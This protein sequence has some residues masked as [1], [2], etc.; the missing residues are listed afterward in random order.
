MDIDGGGAY[1]DLDKAEEI[2]KEASRLSAIDSSKALESAAKARLRYSALTE[3]LRLPDLNSSTT[4]TTTS[5][6]SCLLSIRSSFQS[7]NQDTST[8]S[9][10]NSHHSCQ[11]QEDSNSLRSTSSSVDCITS[12]DSSHLDQTSSPAVPLFTR[13]CSISAHG[14]KPV[15]DI[16]SKRTHTQDNLHEGTTKVISKAEWGL[17]LARPSTASR[18]SPDSPS[19][20][21]PLHPRWR[22]K[23][24][25]LRPSPPALPANEPSRRERNRQ[26]SSLS[27]NS[28][29]ISLESS[30]LE[31]NSSNDTNLRYRNYTNPLLGQATT[32]PTPTD[33][34]RNNSSMTETSTLTSED[35]TSLPEFESIIDYSAAK[36]G[37]GETLRDGEQVRYSVLAHVVP[38]SFEESQFERVGLSIFMEDGRAAEDG[39]VLNYKLVPFKE[40]I[41]GSASKKLDDLNSSVSVEILSQVGEKPGFYYSNAADDHAPF[42]QLPIKLDSGKSSLCNITPTTGISSRSSHN[43]G[44][45]ATEYPTLKSSHE[46]HLS[47]VDMELGDKK[48][49]KSARLRRSIYSLAK[50]GGKSSSPSLDSRRTTEMA[51]ELLPRLDQASISDLSVSPPSTPISIGHQSKDQ[52]FTIKIGRADSQS[53]STY[54]FDRASVGSSKDHLAPYGSDW[55]RLKQ[56]SSSLQEI[57]EEQMINRKSQ[58][59]VAETQQNVADT[60]KALESDT[61][62]YRNNSIRSLDDQKTMN[63][64]ERMTFGL[65]KERRLV[66]VRR[67]LETEREYEK[68]IRLRKIK[69]RSKAISGPI[70]IE[71]SDEERGQDKKKAT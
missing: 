61:G 10:K 53:T 20:Q 71:R 58:Q 8:P 33:G 34:S 56:R 51:S 19:V 13:V 15:R 52:D 18:F 25:L 1:E 43:S 39:Q 57:S 23:P 47:K 50:Y 36:C 37:F 46:V 31:L 21:N 48:Y 24:L 66:D 41:A 44:G 59:D 63:R 2:V 17:S 22:R 7:P 70:L 38:K 27:N 54:E 68:P 9:A 5:N 30:N 14:G 29:L 6:S 32:S 49:S 4:T 45:E 69:G 40:P 64:L 11:A 28:S 16:N 3:A 26:L 42:S 67:D 55:P 65:K 60:L 35:R 12:E 62:N